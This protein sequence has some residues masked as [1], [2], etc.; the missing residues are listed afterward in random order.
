VL[1]GCPL[2]KISKDKQQRI[3]EFVEYK[4]HQGQKGNA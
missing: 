1:I 2:K 4:I 3:D